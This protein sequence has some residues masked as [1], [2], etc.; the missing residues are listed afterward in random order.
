MK[1]EIATAIKF[2]VSKLMTQSGQPVRSP[3]FP[4]PL[5]S[6][7]LTTSLSRH[8]RVWYSVF[9]SSH[10]SPR[11]SFVRSAFCSCRGGVRRRCEQ[12]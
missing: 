5:Q 1:A 2:L 9:L 6:H 11:H 12:G 8:T 10:L 3:P 4:S 7:G